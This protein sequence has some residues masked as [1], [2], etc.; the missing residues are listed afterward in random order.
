MQ[1]NNN[2]RRNF[3]FGGVWQMRCISMVQ[4]TEKNWIMD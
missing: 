4:K 3:Y 1:A 2:R